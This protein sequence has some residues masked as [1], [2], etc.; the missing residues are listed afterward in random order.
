MV[1]DGVTAKVLGKMGALRLGRFALGFLIAV[2][3]PPLSVLPQDVRA[4]VSGTVT[5][6]STNAPMSGVLVTMTGGGVTTTDD[7]GRFVLSDV[8]PGTWTIQALRTGTAPPDGEPRARKIAVLPGEEIRDIRL[9]L[10]GLATLRGRISDEDG[11]SLPGVRVFPLVITYRQGRK[12]LTSP[13][14]LESQFAMTN[15]HGGYEIRVPPGKYFIG[16]DYTPGNRST[17]LSSGNVDPGDG[18]T[19]TYYPGTLD[20]AAAVAIKVGG[21]DFVAADFRVVPK[22]PD[23]WKVSGTLVGAEK[24]SL[25]TSD[26]TPRTF[27]FTARPVITFDPPVVTFLN[28]ARESD[29]AQFEIAGVPRGW[30]DVS[31]SARMA[32][33][34]GGRGILQVEVVDRDVEDL[35]VVLRP[36]QDVPG[37]VIVRGANN[38]FPIE[39]IEIRSGGS[40]FAKPGADGTFTLKGV[41]IGSQ[42]IRVDGLPPDAYVADIRQG[43]VSIFDTARTLSGPQFVV[44]DFSAPLEITV[45]R[46]GGTIQGVVETSRPQNV[47]GAVIALVPLPPHRFV[48]TYYRSSVVGST[49]EFTFRGL[50]PGVYQLYAWETVP[51]TAWLNPDFISTYE[52]Q[53]KTIMVDLGGNASTRVRLIPRDN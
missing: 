31:V 4:T 11:S 22:R 25:P 3:S 20:S 9:R 21:S 46:N 35:R 43:G 36:N 18:T 1:C 5:D 32:D 33:G 24:N 26:P 49:G 34:R 23:S 52:G 28:I 2:L 16:A 15:E 6:G 10:V 40:V 38:V 51:D 19:R 7:L 29:A 47:S 8:L 41:S 50:A 14:D 45:G 27:T 48:Q 12:T 13:T 37:R 44:G 39:Q 17:I 30:Y 42:S 53:G